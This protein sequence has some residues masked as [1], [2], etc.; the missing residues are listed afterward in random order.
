MVVFTTHSPFMVPSNDLPSV[1]IVEDQIVSPRPGQRIPNGT[2]V[3][4]D[5]L[6]TDRDT[7]SRYKVH[8]DTN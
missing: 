3:R 8:S 5:A 6:A 4:S 1:R 7:L 2:K